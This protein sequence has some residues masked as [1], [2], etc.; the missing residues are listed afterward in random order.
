MNPLSTLNIPFKATLAACLCAIMMVGTVSAQE[1]DKDPKSRWFEVEVIVFKYISPD[2]SDEAFPLRIDPPQA[3]ASQSFLVDAVTSLY[4][5]IPNDDSVPNETLTDNL[6]TNT[7]LVQEK[8]SNLL[9]LS[10][11]DTFE[12]FID[13]KLPKEQQT[14]AFLLPKSYFQLTNYLTQGQ[15]RGFIQP[16]LHAAWQQPVTTPSR[17]TPIRLIGGDNYNP[18]FH[19]AGTPRKQPQEP[20]DYFDFSTPDLKEHEFE[21]KKD[22]DHFTKKDTTYSMFSNSFNTDQAIQ[23]KPQGPLSY[24][25]VTEQQEQT[26]LFQRIDHLLS[27]IETRQFTF[28]NLTSTNNDW[29]TKKDLD[30]DL[31]LRDVWELDGFLNIF[32]VGN[33]LHVDSKLHF[34]AMDYVELEQTTATEQANTWLDNQTEAYKVLRTY[35]MDETRRVISHERHYF[36]H[37]KFGMIIEIRRTDLSK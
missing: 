25:P 15:R 4:Y 29:Y 3:R 11:Q 14:H 35:S 24:T 31:Q 33:Y 23:E 22:Q 17:S 10:G 6:E 20:D 7:E 36:D 9:T 32:L 34:R 18:E 5:S 21:K 19:Y 8:G 1:I 13:A 26:E 16:L 28:K 2:Q 12:Y 27:G 30:L 37:P